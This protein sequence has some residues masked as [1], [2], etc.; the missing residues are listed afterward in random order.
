MAL[1]ETNFTLIARMK[2]RSDEL[3]WQ[4]FVGAYEP[5]LLRMMQRRG[6]SGHDARDIVQQVF[7]SMCRSLDQWNPDGGHGSFR[8]W[9]SGVAR[10]VMFK[11]LRSRHRHPAGQGGSDF[12]TR[13]AEIP[14]PPDQSG[15]LQREYDRE[16]FLFAAEQVRREFREQSWSAFWRTAVD[17]RDPAEVARELN[18]ERGSVYMS[19]SRIMARIRQKIAELGEDVE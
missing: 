15:E 12:L 6:F 8:R 4:E 5:F 9:L 17:G 13:I 19:R 10:N 16:L 2:R 11:F 18:V 7:L 3:A 1:P 14:V